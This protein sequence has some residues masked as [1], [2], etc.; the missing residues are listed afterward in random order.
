MRQRPRATFLVDFIA[1]LKT[2]A[3]IAV[4]ALASSP[5]PPPVPGKAVDAR[6]MAGTVLVEL[7]GHEKFGRLSVGEQIPTGSVVTQR[8]ARLR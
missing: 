3:G 5:L 4:D 1:G 6:P 2:A 7:P 8:T